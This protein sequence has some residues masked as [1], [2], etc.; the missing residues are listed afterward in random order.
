MGNV[1][2]LASNILRLGG[3]AQL[4]KQT[5]DNLRNLTQCLDTIL[6][7]EV[8]ACFAEEG[9]HVTPYPVIRD[10]RKPDGKVNVNNKDIFVEI[11][12]VDWPP[13]RD[14]PGINW[15]S[16]QGSKLIQKSIEEAGQLPEDQYGVIIVNPPTLF[17]QEVGIAILEALRGYLTPELYRRISGI[18]LANKRIERSGFLRAFPTVI[19]NAYAYRRCDSELLRL[20]EALA[21]HPEMPGMH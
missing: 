18:I 14:F 3:I 4:G 9:F 21:K 2:R 19:A 6:E 7:L 15:K 16:K 13:P 20:A 10:G 1:M 17:D 12:A 5:K 11:T 8:L